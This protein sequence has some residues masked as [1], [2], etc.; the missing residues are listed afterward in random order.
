MSWGSPT[1]VIAADSETSANSLSAVAATLAVGK[2]AFLML[3][4]DNVATTD[5]NTN[6]V[7]SVDDDKG[8]S[9]TKLREY[10]NS[11]GSAAAGATVAMFYSVITV[12]NPTITAHFASNI[13]AKCFRVYSFTA[14]SNPSISIVGTPVDEATVNADV[15]SLT[16][17]SLANAQHLWFRVI[18]SETDTNGLSSVSSTF[19]Q[20]SG[21]LSGI[22]GSEK[23]HMAL[24]G[25]FVIATATTKT[26]DPTLIDTTVDA[27]DF[28]I[29]F[30][31]TAS[32]TA[33]PNKIYQLN[34][35]IN[36]SY[37]Y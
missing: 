27:A 14:S 33:I 10:T 20:F 24:S 22:G 34:Q 8:N 28:F 37:I 4:C 18:A 16:I 17:G 5:G 25:E 35:A 21:A 11:R 3:A 1:D 31:E 7:T 13:V 12:A 26:S 30:D 29:A 23:G 9:W 19:T 36:R 6:L 15:G 2:V 32:V